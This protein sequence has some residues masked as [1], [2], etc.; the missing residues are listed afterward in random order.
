MALEALAT[1][2]QIGGCNG[3][4]AAVSLPFSGVRC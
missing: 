3:T 4:G 1:V 2:D